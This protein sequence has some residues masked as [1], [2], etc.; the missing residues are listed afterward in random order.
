MQRIAVHKYPLKVARQG[1]RKGDREGGL[2]S[3]YERLDRDA[4]EECL[5]AR[6]AAQSTDDKYSM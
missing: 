2:K 5:A 1:A 6:I 3:Y 4:T